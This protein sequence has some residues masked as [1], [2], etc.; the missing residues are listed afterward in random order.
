[1]NEADR[2]VPAKRSKIYTPDNANAP[3]AMSADTTKPTSPESTQESGIGSQVLTDAQIRAILKLHQT[4]PKWSRNGSTLADVA[5]SLDIPVTEAAALLQRANTEPIKPEPM[6]KSA[7]LLN[8]ASLVLSFLGIFV[9]GTLSL[10][11]ALDRS[12]PCGNTSGCDTVTSSAASMLLGIPIAYLGFV[13]YA[14]LASISAVRGIR[15]LGR[16][17]ALGTV[18]LI[19]SGIGA[20]FSFYLQYLSF[21]QIHAV[22]Y[23][24]L[25][26]AIAM[27]LLFL[28][29]AGLAQ[30]EIPAETQSRDNSLIIAVGLALVAFLGI[31]YEAR[32]LGHQPAIELTGFGGLT[33]LFLT[34]DSLK[35]GPDT[36]PL[37]VVEFSDLVCPSCKAFYPEVNKLLDRSN[38]NIQ[39][40]FRHRPLT[41]NPEHQ[42]AAPAAFI[43]GYAQE[44]GKGWEFVDAMYQHDNPDLQTMDSLYKVAKS[45]G[46]DVSDLKKRMEDKNDPEWKKEAR[47]LDLAEQLKI[48]ETP[49]FILLQSEHV[50]LLLPGNDLF[51]QLNKPEY[52]I[53]LKGNGK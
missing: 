28:V 52:Q 23:W 26:S 18:A 7:V 33:P 8:Y 14:L 17:G 5:E 11:H 41:L 44:K 32:T 3:A 48:A 37:K 22:C 31:G 4:E 45:V 12:I 53:F 29:Q 13:S 19:I 36:A 30:T 40:F 25:T 51:I 27:S 9:A 1:M 24:C 16:T 21:T 35:K 38:G 34:N 43:S 20:L 15:G 49:T 6:P 50:P 39:L 42:M 46:L 47:D 10:S 2:A